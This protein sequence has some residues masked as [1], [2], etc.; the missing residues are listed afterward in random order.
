MTTTRY[1]LC[2]VIDSTGSMQVYLDA[3]RSSLLEIVA[4]SKMIGIESIGI[5]TYKD[6]TDKYV[7]QWSGWKDTYK[8]LETFIC[9]IHA[10]GG[11]DYPE[12]VRTASF[13]LSRYSKNPTIV[14]WF[15]DAPPHCHIAKSSENNM[16]AEKEALGDAFDWIYLCSELCMRSCH[17]FPIIYSS[18]PIALTYFSY[19]AQQTRGSCFQLMN[20]FQLVQGGWNGRLNIF[21][22]SKPIPPSKAV[23]SQNTLSLLMS[24]AGEKCVFSQTCQ[25]LENK[26]NDIC[27]D[28]NEGLLT[29][30]LYMNNIHKSSSVNIISYLKDSLHE[31][32][33][34]S[35]QEHKN[36]IYDTFFFFLKNSQ[37]PM[38]LTYN[39]IFGKYWRAICRDRKDCRRDALIS[40]MSMLLKS[41]EN[42]KQNNDK[43]RFQA[44]LEESYKQHDVIQSLI[45][46]YHISSSSIII[47]DTNDPIISNMKVNDIL[48]LSRSCDIVKMT[49][50]LNHIVESK[51]TPS[52]KIVTRGYNFLPNNMPADDL[53]RCIPHLV[54]EG[55]MFSKRPAC[56]FAMIAVYIKNT[57]LYDI[58]IQYLIDVKGT[59]IDLALPENYNYNFLKMILE[60][61][62]TMNVPIL[63]DPEVHELRKRFLIGR[64]LQSQN[65]SVQLVTGYNSHDTKRPDYKYPC[66]NCDQYRSFTLLDKE[67]I[68]GLC[69]CNCDMIIDNNENISNWYECRQCV[70]HYVIAGKLNVTPKCHF[71]RNDMPTKHVT[72]VKCQ[73]RF[74]TEFIINDNFICP[75]CNVDCKIEPKHQI[76]N[77][78]VKEIVLQNPGIING[79]NNVSAFFACS[80]IFKAMSYVDISFNI[81]HENQTIAYNK[82]TVHDVINIME[83][84]SSSNNETCCICFK[85]I[86]REFTDCGRKGCHKKVCFECA[87]S[88]YRQSKP[89]NIVTLSNL[90]CPFCKKIPSSKILRKTNRNLCM[91]KLPPIIN[92]S[93]VYGWCDKCY[94]LKESHSRVCGLDVTLQTSFTCGDCVT[95]KQYKECPTCHIMIEKLLGCNHIHCTNCNTHWCFECG[96]ASTENDIYKHMMQEHGTYGIDEYSDH[97][98][99][100]DEY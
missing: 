30:V 34:T 10:E 3:L 44:F 92:N 87:R 20:S 42:K 99:D 71:C 35:F 90:Y 33:T 22:R 64:L 18:D 57:L 69:L 29:R 23:I 83:L 54:I 14:I 56:I 65:N 98:S 60:V 32:L 13:E 77:T 24:I 53:F 95:Q 91:L 51:Q 82:K 66:K 2:F 79:I 61:Y 31:T 43:E 86:K 81:Q 9:D 28:F 15:A 62:D 50:I 27:D 80:S 75:E 52:E 94:H 58:A 48:E 7:T 38:M 21:N 17:V 67:G 84:I 8:D 47:I 88:W 97:T 4:I 72:C 25:Q 59:W 68:C 6:Y 12:A 45:S 85:D 63:T 70:S 46:E 40:S 96:K 36:D 73:N 37:N 11:D 93:M 19:M 100:D 1:D 74:V 76:I 26:N 78:N 16:R 41:F 39:P 55:I 5:L 89:G 49:H